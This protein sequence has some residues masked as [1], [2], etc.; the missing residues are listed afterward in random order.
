MV[1]RNVYVD[2]APVQYLTDVEYTHPSGGE[3]GTAKITVG[4]T[5]SNRSLF[6]TGAPVEIYVAGQE[7]WTGEVI[8]KPSNS[9]H[10]NLT[11]TVEAESRGAQAEYGKVDRMF[12]ERSRA[13]I[14]RRAIDNEIESHRF[15]RYITYG[16]DTSGWSADTD[17][18]ELTNDDKGINKFGSDTLFA[19]VFS[20]GSGTYELTY[21][22]V[23]A[24][25]GLGHRLSRLD[26][27]LIVN[28]RGNVFTTTVEF[29]DN[30]GNIFEWELD[31]GGTAS[32]IMHELNVE[33]A[34]ISTGGTPQTL[35]YRFDV[36]GRLPENKGIAID[37]ARTLP[38]HTQ[39]RDLGITYDIDDTDD[40]IS[41]RV[42]SSILSLA[43]TLAL[44]AGA[45][46]YMDGDT[47][48]FESEGDEL[49]PHQIT[50]DAS[51]TVV[52]VDVDRDFDV[53]NVVT[54]QGRGDLQATFADSASIRFYNDR[55]PHPEP[56]NDGSL[57]SRDQLAA[58]ARGFLAENAW[59]DS[60]ITFTLSGAKWRDATQGQGIEVDWPKEDV[61]GTFTIDTVSMTT[62]GYTELGLSGETEV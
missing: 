49:F 62:E 54:I 55:A 40:Q 12:I 19:G 56:I 31:L 8:G 45:T 18:F 48:I 57:R 42:N 52:D 53:K 37:M 23:P 44:E 13:E 15:K 11:L 61:V 39:S 59:E 2:G 50:D 28:N 7:E 4:N 1:Q 10:D 41:R 3:I 60:A 51:T 26:T 16:D 34:T 21:D 5:D 24:E 32:W 30:Q 22:N 27:R 58:R 25:A 29:V 38:F 33:D 6:E 43:E 14:L 36:D 47:L 17:I 9:S 20:G 35:T 46:V